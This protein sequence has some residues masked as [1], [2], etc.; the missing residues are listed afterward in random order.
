MSDG[1]SLNQIQKSL[2]SQNATYLSPKRKGEKKKG[3]QTKTKKQQN[4]NNCRVLK[5]P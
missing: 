5:T 1:Q 4:I 2:I 3:E